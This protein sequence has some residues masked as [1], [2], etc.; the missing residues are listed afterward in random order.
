[1]HRIRDS[2]ADA[3]RLATADMYRPTIYSLLISLA[4]GILAQ[5]AVFNFVGPVTEITSMDPPNPPEDLSQLT[6]FPLFEQL[7]L[8]LAGFVLLVFFPRIS[9]RLAGAGHLSLPTVLTL[10]MAVFGLSYLLLFLPMLPFLSVMPELIPGMLLSALHF[11]ITYGPAFSAAFLSLVR[12]SLVAEQ[13]RRGMKA[14][15]SRGLATVVLVLI[16]QFLYWPIWDRFNL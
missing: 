6:E 14:M 4:F 2:Q 7:S 9:R 3:E 11:A 13:G 16:W 12:M 1:M 5:V 8:L 10:S 15:L